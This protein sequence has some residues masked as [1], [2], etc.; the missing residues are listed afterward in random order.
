MNSSTPGRVTCRV[1]VPEETAVRVRVEARRPLEE[2]SSR[3][4][5]RRVE[6]LPSWRAVSG[7][8]GV[9]SWREQQVEEG[10]LEEEQGGEERE[11]L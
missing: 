2:N 3:L 7:G 11:M 9:D 1:V 6:G 10:G 8:D 5:L 4:Y